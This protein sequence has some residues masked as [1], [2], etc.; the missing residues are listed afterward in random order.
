MTVHRKIPFKN[1]VKNLRKGKYRGKISEIDYANTGHQLFNTIKFAQQLGVTKDFLMEIG[2]IKIK[3]FSGWK[4]PAEPTVDELLA[5]KA[6][7]E[8]YL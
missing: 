7:I 1:V 5:C 3:D 8:N 6:K 4:L 2:L